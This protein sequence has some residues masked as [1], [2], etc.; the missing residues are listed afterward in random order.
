MSYDEIKFY[1]AM[2]LEKDSNI[3]PMITLLFIAEFC[4]NINMGLI[5]IIGREISPEI[6]LSNS[7]TYY[8]QRAALFSY[9]EKCGNFKKN[10]LIS[11][12]GGS[13]K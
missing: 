13:K 7:T 5:N 3:T 6:D 8:E 4:V 1:M 9:V 11:Y 10:L 12:I 2:L